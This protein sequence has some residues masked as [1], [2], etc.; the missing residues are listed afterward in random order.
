[1]GWLHLLSAEAQT[2]CPVRLTQAQLCCEL[3]VRNQ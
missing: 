2:S 3:P 1:M